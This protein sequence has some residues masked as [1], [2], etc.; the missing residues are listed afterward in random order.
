MRRT[1]LTTTA[2][3]LDGLSCLDADGPMVPAGMVDG[4]Q[5]FAHEE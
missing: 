1:R 3:A 4:R 2:D 5:V